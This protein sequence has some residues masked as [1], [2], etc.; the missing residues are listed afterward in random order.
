MPEAV[1]EA[2][3][4]SP[5]HPGEQDLQARI[6]KR[7]DM[8]RLGRRVIRDFMPDQH[9]AFFEQLPFL[10]I[11]G[12]DDAGWPWASL[13]SGHPGFMQSPDP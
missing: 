2:V 11:G 12:V 10:V 9:R 1:K 7:D 6:G 3:E 8:E 5:F 13:A 4:R